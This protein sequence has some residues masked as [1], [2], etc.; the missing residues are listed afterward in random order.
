[1]SQI[2]PNMLVA[3]STAG[4]FVTGVQ[5]KSCNYDV[6]FILSCSL[7]ALK[8]HLDRDWFNYAPQRMYH[9]PVVILY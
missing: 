2:F 1:M 3:I 5:S 6:N 8:Q 9:A 7:K 4:A